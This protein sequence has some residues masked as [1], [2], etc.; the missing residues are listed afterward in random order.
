MI[1]VHHLENS[2][3]QR[4]L[5]LLEELELAYEITH[6]A[7]DPQ[8][9]RAPAA[10]RAVHPL[11]K[12]PILEHDGSVLAESGAIVDYLVNRVAGGRLGVAPAAPGYADYLYWL[13][14]A[15]GSGA[16]PS[17]SGS[18]STSRGPRPTY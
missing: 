18:C 8:T 11:G 7:R 3:S 10:M 13:H 1:R 9:Q 12:S 15:E 2:R 6:Y 17:S 4:L 14:F 5:W 16:F